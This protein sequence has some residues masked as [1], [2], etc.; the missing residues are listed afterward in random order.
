MS[1]SKHLETGKKL[2]MVIPTVKFVVSVVVTEV[3]SEGLFTKVVIG[4][5]V[6]S[7]LI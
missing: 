5:M 6:V 3:V 4:L 7:S 2:I 1:C